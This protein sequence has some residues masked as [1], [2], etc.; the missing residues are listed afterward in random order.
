MPPTFDPKPLVLEGRCARLEPLHP[1]H[2]DDLFA[3]GADPEV[4]RYMPLRPPRERDEMRQWIESVLKEGRF[5]GILPF[6]IVHRDSGRAV[7]ST[8]FFDIRPADR[9][10][11]IGWTWIGKPWQR[12][13]LNTECK[14]LLLRHAFEDL[15]A[16][17][18]QFKTDSRNLQSQKAL[19]RIGAVKEGVLRKQRIN[20]DGYIRD[21]VYY[22]IL[23]E[24]WP[25]A[26]RRLES[27][28]ESGLDRRMAR[29][30]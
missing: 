22:S 18:V 29:N 14:Y 17:R 19:E 11:E 7:G 12:T 1:G 10:L 13:A 23:D 24:E 28:L 25:A 16:L 2:G 4:W 20:W 8:R 15:G 21:S 26:K 30:A 6:A 9:A 3:A 5:G 27:L